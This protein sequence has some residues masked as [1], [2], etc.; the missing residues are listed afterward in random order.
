MALTMVRGGQFGAG[1]EW[2]TGTLTSALRWAGLQED[3]PDSRKIKRPLQGTAGGAKT[4]SQVR[5]FL[6][7]HLLCGT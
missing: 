6:G 4:L 7:L 5:S 1:A 2:R 3:L